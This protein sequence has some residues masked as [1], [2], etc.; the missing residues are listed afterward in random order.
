MKHSP[1]QRLFIYRA[2]LFLVGYTITD[3]TDVTVIFASLFLRET[4]ETL[5][6]SG[7]VPGPLFCRWKKQEGIRKKNRKKIGQIFS[8]G[9]DGGGGGG[10]GGDRGDEGPGG[11]GSDVLSTVILLI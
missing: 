2:F 7:K 5:G 11:G 8:H 4:S 3:L 10:G 1:P 9:L 6:I